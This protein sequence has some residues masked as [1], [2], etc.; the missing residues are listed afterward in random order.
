ML[1]LQIAVALYANVWHNKIFLK[2]FFYFTKPNIYQMKLLYAICPEQ[3]VMVIM[4]AW[5]NVFLSSSNWKLNLVSLLRIQFIFRLSYLFIDECSCA[6]WN[7]SDEE[8]K[9]H[10]R[11]EFV[12][13]YFNNLL[14][15]SESNQASGRKILFW[16]SFSYSWDWKQNILLIEYHYFRLD[17]FHHIIQF[18]WEFRVI[19]L[20]LFGL[21]FHWNIF[22]V[23]LEINKEIHMN[24]SSKAFLYDLDPSWR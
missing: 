8:L 14:L 12:N 23:L 21:L 18:F 4:F 3:F 15:L 16:K 20:W 10:K 17:H 11:C 22:K 7:W 1:I 6:L 13:L 2:S 19:T 5:A 24:F 9:N